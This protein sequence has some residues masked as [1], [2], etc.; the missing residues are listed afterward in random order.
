M[1]FCF[2]PKGFLWWKNETTTPWR[3]FCFLTCIKCSARCLHILMHSGLSY[4]DCISAIPSTMATLTYTSEFGV[5]VWRFTS[6]LGSPASISSMCIRALLHRRIGLFLPDSEWFAR[7]DQ[8][9]TSRK[10]LPSMNCHWSQGLFLLLTVPCCT[11]H[12]RVLEIRLIFD[13]FDFPLSLKSA[14]QTRWQ[15]SEEIHF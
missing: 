11:A 14:T 3:I 8:K 4:N 15:G 1:F 10:Q 2:Q 5:L 9:S 12:S 6:L 13:R 7:A